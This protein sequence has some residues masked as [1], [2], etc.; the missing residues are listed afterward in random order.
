VPTRPDRRDHLLPSYLTRFIGRQQEIAYLAGL[1]IG[2]QGSGGDAPRHR[3]ITLV[4]VGGCGK[5]RLAIEVA[6]DLLRAGTGTDG[7]N[8]DEV[9]WVDLASVAAPAELPRA[10]AEAMHVPE[11]LSARPLDAL[12][13]RLRAQQLL[14]VLDNCEHLAAACGHLAQVLLSRCPG[15][16]LLLTSRVP[17][18]VADETVYAVPPL[19][20]DVPDDRRSADGRAGSDATRLFLDRA[21]LGAAEPSL[22]DI[23]GICR[24]LDG[25]PLAIELAA[26]WMRVLT[27]RDLLAELYRS[28]NFLS[29]TSPTLAGRHRSMHAV[30][31]SSWQRLSDRDQRVFGGLAAFRGSFSLE[32]A[33]EVCGATLSSLSSLTETYLIQRLPESEPETR[34][35]IHELVRRFAF[36]RL[37]AVDRSRADQVRQQHLVYFLSLVEQAEKSWDTPLEAQWLE[38]LRTEQANLDAALRWAM[39]SQPSECALRLSAGLFTYWVYTS[40]LETYASALE[41]AVSLP[42]SADSPTSTRARAKALN[43]AGYAAAIGSDF[44]RAM[45]RFNEAL[46]LCGRLNAAS[47]LAWSLRGRGFTSRLTGDATASQADAEHSLGICRAT[48][49]LRGESWSVHDL[50]ETAFASGDL[51]RAQ[52]LLEEGME[53]FEAQGVDFGAYRAGIMLGNVHRRRGRWREAINRYEHALARQ[54]ELHFVTQGGDILDGLAE[55][56]VALHKPVVA[57]RLFGA[58]DAWRWNYGFARYAFLVPDHERSLASAR[59]Q[60]EPGRWSAD[61]DAGWNMDADGAMDEASS[62]ARYLLSTLA[63]QDP[64]SLTARELEVL[65]AVALGLGS[66][67]IAAQLV[68]SPRTVHA[69]LRSIFRKLNVSTR[70]AAVHEAS[71]LDL[72]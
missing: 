45:A 31:E 68:V 22:K 61:Y 65:Q 42:W 48:G 35:H 32:A 43:V 9:R 33:R 29:S 62:C 1:L 49:D 55:V 50:G 34:Y 70:T 60:L 66:A 19:Q 67:E 36:D 5:T 2:S 12:V 44:E 57:A 63:E 51:D 25:L 72:V 13:K 10:V 30:L 41:Q 47:S 71:L 46:V 27:T 6:R 3:L 54:R 4:G 14:L 69:H 7:S 40:P 37:E 64:A 26:S 24:H 38:R 8:A 18:H 17:L 11:A 21:E 16:V 52:S 56:A 15:L 20:M 39:R 28:N 53:R 23:E 58:G 59:R